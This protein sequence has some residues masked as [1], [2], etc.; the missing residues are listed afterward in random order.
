M[1]Q[2]TQNAMSTKEALDNLPTMETTAI[3]HQML[4]I[5]VVAP[6]LLIPIKVLANGGKFKWL[7]D[8]GSIESEFWIEEAV[9]VE[10]LLELK[11]WL[12][13]NFVDL[14]LLQEMVN[15]LKLS[16]LNHF[17]VTKSD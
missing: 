9:V 16:A 8:T 14:Y 5:M 7:K 4:S 10:D 17:M 3:Q 2:Q 13:T 1:F 6:N 15:G 11:S 12:E